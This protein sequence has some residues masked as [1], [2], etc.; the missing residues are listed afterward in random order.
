MSLLNAFDINSRYYYLRWLRLA[1]GSKGPHDNQPGAS[2]GLYHS[3]I[4]IAAQ[5]LAPEQPGRP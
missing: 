1:A 2:W 5:Q 3:N 4:N